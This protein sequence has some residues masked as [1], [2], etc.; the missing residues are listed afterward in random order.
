M[1]EETITASHDWETFLGWGLGL[2]FCLGLVFRED[3]MCW[4]HGS[5]V[6]EPSNTAL[7]TGLLFTGVCCLVSYIHS[8]I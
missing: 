8:Q 4:G 6:L 3:L 5:I 7:F 2:R 1:S